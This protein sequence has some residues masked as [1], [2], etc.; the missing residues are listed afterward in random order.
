MEHHFTGPSYTI[1]IEEELMICDARS[2][3]LVNAIE[4]LLEEAPEGE[5]KPERVTQ[6]EPFGQAGGVDVHH[7]VDE[8]FHFRRF[9]RLPDVANGFA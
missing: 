6:P 3:D 1:G 2:F 9:S 7:H 8:R 4:S 5:I